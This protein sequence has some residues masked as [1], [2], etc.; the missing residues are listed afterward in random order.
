MKHL[1]RLFLSLLLGTGSSF[2]SAQSVTVSVN[3]F[4]DP[5]SFTFTGSNSLDLRVSEL[6]PATGT[7]TSTHVLV[8]SL[9]PLEEGQQVYTSTYQG[10]NAA[11][12][13][14]QDAGVLFMTLPA[15]TAL[16]VGTVASPIVGVIQRP[17]SWANYAL[18]VPSTSLGGASGSSA[19]DGAALDL[20]LARG[21]EAFTGE[22]AFTIISADE[23]QFEPFTITKDGATSISLSG[24]TLMRD[25]NRFYA[26]VTNLSAGAAYDA[27]IFEL[28][29]TNISDVD[30]DG[31]PDLVDS[32]IS[33]TGTPVLVPGEY[34]QFPFGQVLGI[35]STRGSTSYMG[36]V[37]LDYYNLGGFIYQA[38]LQWFVVF[39]SFGSSHFFYSYTLG[40]IW[41][42]EVFG[43]WYYNYGTGQ[44]GQFT[45]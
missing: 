39:S 11:T 7:N 18:Q 20:N 26:T 42:S 2:L 23:V 10:I 32:A 35:S 28:E 5:S 22:V 6:I 38:D 44:W 1:N 36:D 16:P 4:G 12:G 17:G 24:G 43:G 9:T 37:F 30:G 21:S 34:V 14:I 29:V 19:I 27:L 33:G 41:T 25:G 31:V 13:A 3:A 40:W 8:E 45:Q 15:D